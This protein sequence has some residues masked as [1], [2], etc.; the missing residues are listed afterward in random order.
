MTASGR[1]VD[2]ELPPIMVGEVIAG[3]YEVVREIGCG[4]MARVLQVKDLALPG[5][6]VALKLLHFR[7]RVEDQYFVRFRNEVVFARR[8]SHPHIARIHDFG[9]TA[10]GHHYLTME[11]VQGMDLATA[12]EQRPFERMTVS[13]A[14]KIIFQIAVALDYAHRQGIVH[15]DVKP[16]NI[17]LESK[18]FV[19]LTDFGVARSMTVDRNITASG[20]LVG[21]VEYM[22]P[23]LLR[24]ERPDP[25]IDIYAL[26]IVA[27]EMV[28]GQLPF[29]DDALLVLIAKQLNHDAPQMS[30]LVPNVPSWFQEFVDICTEKNPKDRFQSASELL[31]DLWDRLASANI[32]PSVA[33]FPPDFIVPEEK[34]T[35]GFLSKLFSL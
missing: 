33:C 24:G 3:R 2:V 28:T 19:K 16:G 13:E 32:T 34:R 8:L 23:E 11:Y 9:E 25:R 6:E 17:L 15:R 31:H 7:A 20:E 30:E 5:E 12:L 4:G 29:Y 18:G 27:F 26:G 22:A 10:N 35:F 14:S 1:P 21:T